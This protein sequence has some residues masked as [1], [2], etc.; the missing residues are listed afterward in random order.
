MSAYT[1]NF[2]PEAEL[3]ETRFKRDAP[4]RLTEQV[5]I[6]HP[7]L[8]KIAITLLYHKECRFATAQD[9]GKIQKKLDRMASDMRNG[10]VKSIVDE[11]FPYCCDGDNSGARGAA[12]NED[13]VR[14]IEAEVCSGSDDAA[15]SYV[16][17]HRSRCMENTRD[18]CKTV[19][20]AVRLLEEEYERGNKKAKTHLRT[21]RLYD[22]PTSQEPLSK[23]ELH[24]VVRCAEHINELMG[25]EFNA[26]FARIISLER[27]KATDKEHMYFH[28]TEMLLECFKYRIT[29]LQTGTSC[30]SGRRV[31][32]A[33]SK[34]DAF[35]AVMLVLTALD[36]L[37][38]YDEDG[39][40][41]F[42][43]IRLLYCPGTPL[44][45]TDLSDW[46]NSFSH[47]YRMRGKA[48]RVISFL[49]WGY[50]TTDILD[51]IYPSTP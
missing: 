30:P 15:W 28:H 11:I 6:R 22:I 37:R 48:I 14:R 13:L 5:R 41:L 47:V 9:E 12:I 38:E 4:S 19:E 1:V 33:N 25:D 50:S 36:S 42:D 34:A 3:E 24:H 26:V 46:G 44:Y 31:P 10:C 40:R 39:E 51:L 7:E 2:A 21:L 17:A 23:T 18:L 27:K 32:D 29:R 20:K 8:S 16:L 35:C 43:V 45:K 49:L